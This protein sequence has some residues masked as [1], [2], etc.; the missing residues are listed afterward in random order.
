MSVCNEGGPGYPERHHRHLAG[1]AWC[2]AGPSAPVRVSTTSTLSRQCGGPDF[3]ENF[4]LHSF[5]SF[6]FED[7]CSAVL[8]WFL[9]YVCISHRYTCAP[10]PSTSP[11]PPGPHRAPR[12]LPGLHGCVPLAVGVTHA[13]CVCQ[14][15][16]LNLSHPLL[17]PYDY[18]LILTVSIQFLLKWI[19]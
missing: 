18:V 13:V 5:L 12:E 6:F 14:C 1:A 8:C 15:H 9:L 7:N 3:S 17:P 4:R 2:A 16:S 10:S 11:P 19:V